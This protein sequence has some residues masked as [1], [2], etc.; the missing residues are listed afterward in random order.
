MHKT[1]VAVGVATLV[2][3]AGCNTEKKRLE[4]ELN[5]ANSRIAELEQSVTQAGIR[6]DS[7][8]STLS[9]AEQRAQRVRDS[10]NDSRETANAAV[11][12]A[13]RIEARLQ[14]ERDTHRRTADSLNQV[15]LALEGTV[16]ER[17]TMVAS[18]ET[19]LKVALDESDRNR[20]QK[21]SLLAFIDD[22]RPWYEY[23]KKDSGRNW[24]KKLFGAGRAKKPTTVEPTFQPRVEPNLEAERP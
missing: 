3:T 16:K 21:D 14:A 7:L 11:V 13:Q 20:A 1:I 6:A 5:L 18:L 12:K 2:L 15:K 10:L 17:E 22:L 4:G 9:L 23:Y 19:Q 24:A 8:A